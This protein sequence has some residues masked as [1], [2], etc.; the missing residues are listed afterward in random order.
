MKIVIRIVYSNQWADSWETSVICKACW[1]TCHQEPLRTQWKAWPPRKSTKLW[2]TPKCRKWWKAW[3]SALNALTVRVMPI[4][5]LYTKSSKTLN[6]TKS[7]KRSSTFHL[8]SHCLSFL[9]HMNC[10]KTL[11]ILVSINNLIDKL[12]HSKLH[13]RFYCKR[14][15][16]AK[17][18]NL[19]RNHKRTGWA[20]RQDD[21]QGP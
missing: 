2:R 21:A 3:V 19:C 11:T 10:L 6:Y 4:S 14:R 16:L 8:F 7:S 5:F 1:K 15:L 18:V 20:G 17:C 13:F 12:S 9:Y